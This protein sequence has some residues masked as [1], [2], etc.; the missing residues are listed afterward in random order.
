MTFLLIGVFGFFGL[1][2]LLWFPRSLMGLKHKRRER[3][4]LTDKYFIRRFEPNQRL[5]HIFVIISFEMLAFTGMILKFSNMEWAGYLARLIGGVHVAGVIHRIGAV[6]TFGYFF[7]H[8]FMLIRTKIR[9]KIPAGRFVFGKSS[10]MFNKQDVKDFVATIK[11]F[12]GRGPRPEYGRWTYWEK[13]DYMAVFWGVAVIGFSGL[14]L[15]FPELFTR[16]FPGWLINVAQIIHS[17][18]AL[19]AVGFI[20]TIHFFNTHLRPDAFPMDTVIFTGL[21]PMADY[22]LERPRE[23]EELKASGR[24][25]K[26]LVKRETIPAWEKVV[27]VFGYFF[28]VFGLTL[29]GL[30]I[31]SVL[32]GYH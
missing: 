20:F 13:F 5:T 27:K 15:W 4:S 14:I 31:Y 11:W 22:K 6:I 24:L 12:V 2:L 28:L 8:L 21:V 26:V 1:H 7:F 10:L 17:D 25:R 3:D 16:I 32:T 23:Y 30:I 29:V 18:E 9:K 19:L